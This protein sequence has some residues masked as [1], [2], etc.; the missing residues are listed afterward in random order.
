MKGIQR[1]IGQFF[2][3]QFYCGLDIGTDKIKASLS[4]VVDAYTLELLAVS[5]ADTRGLALASI[6]DISEFSSCVSAAVNGVM[7][8]TKIKVSDI[9]MGI[10]GEF[11]E[12]R[13]S[14]A[15]I[16]L[17]ERGNKIVT[18]RDL[19]QARQQARM[20]GVKLDEEVVCDM[21]QQFK[22]DDVNVAL[23]PAGLYGRKLE[24]ET[25][26]VLANITRLR[27]LTKGVQQA[28][29]EV[30]DVFFNA[31]AAA[32]LMLDKRQR[33]EGC[34]FI[35]LG[36][37]ST[38]MLVYKEGLLKYFRRIPVGAEAMTRR[39]AMDINVPFALAE[40]IKKSYGRVLDGI[41]PMIPSAEEILIK[42]EQGFMPV[43]RDALIMSMEPDVK[44]IVE[45]L[46]EVVTAS[47]YEGQLKAGVVVVGGGALLAGLMER[48][49]NDMHMPVVVG[50]NI[51]GL[52]SAAIYCVST[53]LAE[54]GYKNTVRYK[55]DVQKP[56]DWL[57]RMKAKAEE[58]SNEY[59]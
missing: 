55:L 24:V 11:I 42:K 43:K 21:V 47:N 26:L 32:D 7:R 56:K 35:D 38:L 58:L 51:P 28:G 39:L 8:K 9:Y 30:D 16:P 6:N 41:S 59:F 53:G 57:G 15:L 37:G 48:I 40:D 19:A 34:V 31:S 5:D 44:V 18:N 49:E 36:A 14:R 52:N 50:R 13:Q 27:N 25:L 2:G 33:Q 10:G 54:M 46:R 22:V 29:F 45:N 1:F 20:L 4:R 12:I 3:D 17:V 23:N